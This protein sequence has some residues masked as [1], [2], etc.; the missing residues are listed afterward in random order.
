MRVAAV[1]IA[2]LL[3]PVPPAVP[4]VCRLE[5][6]DD[7]YDACGTC[8]AECSGAGTGATCGDGE[9]CPERVPR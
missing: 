8:N 2:R 4:Q 5:Q 6:C 3:V 9:V 1:R 7:G